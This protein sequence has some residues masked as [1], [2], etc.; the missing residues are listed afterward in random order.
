MKFHPILPLIP[1]LLANAQAHA[2]IKLSALFSDHAVLQSETSVPVW[3]WADPGEEVTVEFA[4]QKKQ[5]KAGADGK[6]L[7]KLDT[8]AASATPGELVATAGAKTLKATDVLV[9]EVWLGSGQ[10]NMA[11][12][13]SRAKDLEAEK[14]AATDTTIRMFTEKSGAAK[15][16]QAEC[17]GSWLVCSAETVPNFSAT[18]YFFGREVQKQIK[19][20]MGLI[21]SSVG[22]TPIESWID[23]KAQHAKPELSDF[24]KPSDKP[25][26]AEQAAALYQKQL[27]KWALDVKAAK[28]EKKSLPRRPQD[29]IQLRERKANVGGL[30]NGKIAPLVGYALRGA[31][32]Y[33]GEANAQPG[34]SNFY[35]FQLPLLVE[36]WRQRWGSDFPFAWVQL[37]NFNRGENWCEVREG[38]F[39]TLRLPKTGMAVTLDIGEAGN[40]HPVNKQEVGRRLSLWAL[41]SVYGKGG[42]VS[43][44]R[45]SGSEINGGNVTLNFTHTDGG[46]V[47]KGETKGFVLAGEDKQWHEAAAKIDGD[48]II[49]SSPDCAKPIAARY[50]WDAQPPVT[51]WN[52]AG[53]PASPFRTDD[54]AILAEAPAKP[55]ARARKK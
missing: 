8:M 37:P 30:Y 6:W 29:P 36:D 52:G 7:I 48:K 9:G 3:G 41:G 51:L 53:L 22:G 45:F 1:L 23:D 39:K 15:T 11:M 38:M 47:F 25:F 27:A 42:A 20:P 55:A 35:Q 46:L 17:K 5:A 28:A 13:V 12:T 49:L 32:W 19:V 31:I 24:F 34:K 50:A 14:A 10:S 43:G 4:G 16:P 2:E 18:L 26:N 40:I 54:W 33:Q 44:P 21:N